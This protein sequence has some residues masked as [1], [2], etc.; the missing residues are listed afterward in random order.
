MNRDIIT[1]DRL[2]RSAFAP[3]FGCAHVIATAEV[4][5][6]ISQMAV[7]NHPLLNR[8]NAAVGEARLY[9]C[10]HRCDSDDKG[11]SFRPSSTAM[12]L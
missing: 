1:L 3:K 2:I 8:F 12:T 5:L 11:N 6:Q 7:N 10:S 4:T 9:H